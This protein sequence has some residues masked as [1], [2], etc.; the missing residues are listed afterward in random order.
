M[1]I[2]ANSATQSLTALGRRLK[3]RVGQS[4]NALVDDLA[5]LATGS[6]D[7]QVMIFIGAE[8]EVW[9][10]GKSGP[11]RL[12]VLGAEFNDKA[13]SAINGGI[14][15]VQEPQLQELIT[16][17]R[18]RLY[19]THSYDEVVQK[20]D[21]TFVIVPTPSDHDRMFSNKY[22]ITALRSIGQ[23]LRSKVGRHVVANFD[24]FGGRP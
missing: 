15:P 9:R 17:A 10:R 2:S 3:R 22:L 12:A 7:W 1:D 14:A 11:E 19:G 21:I 4:L 18:P 16:R 6:H 24:F 8:I 20:S 5:G 13:V 23:S